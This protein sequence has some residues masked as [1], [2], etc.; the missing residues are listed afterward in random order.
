MGAF[1]AREGLVPDLVLCSTAVRAT[2]TWTLVE[3]ELG[4]GAEVRFTDDLYHATPGSVL[5]LLNSLPDSYETVLLVGHNPTFEDLALELAGNGKEKALA[6]L[7]RK[8]PTAAL[9][10][11]RFNLD[12]WSEVGPGQGFLQDLVRPKSLGD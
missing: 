3:K 1:M 7:D 5:A 4:G 9:A 10:V 6:Q 12:A 2:E 8:Y 11:I